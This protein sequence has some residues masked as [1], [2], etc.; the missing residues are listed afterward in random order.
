MLALRL[1]LSQKLLNRKVKGEQF[2]F[3]DEPFAFFDE[4][5]TRYALNTLS[6]LSEALTQ[7]WIVAQDYPEGSHVEFALSIHC[8]RDQDSL[9]V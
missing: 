5:R 8:R 6:G 4:E 1:A 9:K 7:I 2:A 3:L